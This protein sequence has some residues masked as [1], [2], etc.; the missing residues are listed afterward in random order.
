M[1]SLSNEKFSS[2]ALE[3]STVKQLFKGVLFQFSFKLRFSSVVSWDRFHFSNSK[4]ILSKL[5]I[6][7]LNLI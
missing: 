3:I 6:S 2:T 5:G 1:R 4:I 7:S